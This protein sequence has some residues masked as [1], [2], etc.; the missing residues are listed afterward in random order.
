MKM[1]PENLCCRACSGPHYKIRSFTLN[2]RITE[3]TD[4]FWCASVILKSAQRLLSTFVFSNYTDFNLL[5]VCILI[6]RH[7][8][9]FLL[10]FCNHY[11]YCTLT[12]PS[13]QNFALY[14]CMYLYVLLFYEI[15]IRPS[16]ER[17]EREGR[18][19]REAK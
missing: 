13:Y 1:P 7:P 18:G 17:K 12:F 2:Y 10:P 14:A 3:I 16:V 11:L 8:Q 19:A 9:N 4:P 6:N 5:R 15:R